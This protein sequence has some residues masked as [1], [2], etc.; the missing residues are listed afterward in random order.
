MIYFLTKTL[1]EDSKI[2]EKSIRS[3]SL[4]RFYGL[5]IINATVYTESDE[6][7]FIGLEKPKTIMFIRIRNILE[8]ALPKLILKF[9][10]DNFSS[11]KVRF[12]ILPFII[13]ILLCV[14]ILLGIFLVFMRAEDL[15]ALVPP[16]ITASL[17]VLFTK[18]ELNWVDKKIKKSIE[19]LK[20]N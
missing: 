1:T 10:K 18:I 2:I 4:E 7:F 17:F 16:L 19:N 9:D 6:T 11:Y 14:R 12:G 13:G 20:N 3:Y 15:E 5:D 8:F